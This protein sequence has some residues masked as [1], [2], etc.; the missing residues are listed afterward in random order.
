MLRRTV[1]L[2]G[3]AV[4]I[5]AASAVQAQDR[6]A[7]GQGF[8]GLGFGFGGMDIFLLQMPEV[9][10]ELTIN[11]EQKGLIDAAMADIR[12]QMQQGIRNFGGGGAGG[13]QNLSE[14]ERNKLIEEGRKRME[15]FNKKSD[16]TVKMILDDKQGERFGQLRL[17]RAGVLA[18][19]RQDVTEKLGITKEQT[20]KMRKIQEDA[21]RVDFRALFNPNT[22]QEE[23]DKLSK[24]MRDNQ[25]KTNTN[26]LNVLSDEQKEKWAK[27]QGKKFEF[28]QQMGFGFGPGGRP[29]GGGD[30]QR[31]P[32]TKKKTDR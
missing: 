16:E 29:P 21:P 5:A 6:P 2:S 18:F 4:V 11:D 10:K 31:P 15:E 13:F 20:D 19:Y 28:P 14:E 12:D 32:T 3:L 17:Q 9:Q 30:Q 22:S 27:M 25:E 26:I 24:E 7:R 8:G 1:F 23:R